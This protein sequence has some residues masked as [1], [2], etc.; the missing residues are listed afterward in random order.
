[1]VIVM[2]HQKYWPR[3]LTPCL[4]G[5]CPSPLILLPRNR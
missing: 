1:V 5:L 4:L 2:L 3:R